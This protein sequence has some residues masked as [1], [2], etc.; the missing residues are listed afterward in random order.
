MQQNVTKENIYSLRASKKNVLKQKVHLLL[1]PHK[2]CYFVLCA[3]VRLLRIPFLKPP[4]LV[5]LLLIQSLWLSPNSLHLPNLLNRSLYLI[6]R[7]RLANL[8]LLIIIILMLLYMPYL[9]NLR[10][11][12]IFIALMFLILSYLIFFIL[13]EINYVWL[14]CNRV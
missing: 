9:S 4:L 1:P 11:L 13:K 2:M 5:L 12:Q 14:C 3:R 7:N 8:F 10:R 6:P